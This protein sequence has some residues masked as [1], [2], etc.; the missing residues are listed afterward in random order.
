MFGQ[1]MIRELTD[2]TPALD[3][4]MSQV[5]E[6]RMEYLSRI[7]A[8]ELGCLPEDPRVSHSVVSIQWQCFR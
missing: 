7:V 6:P 1:L 2:P 8:T 4:V 5:L 3:R